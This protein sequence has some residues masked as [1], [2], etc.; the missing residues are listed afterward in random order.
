MFL[1]TTSTPSCAQS[2]CVSSCWS[3]YNHWKGCLRWRCKF[4]SIR[5]T[6]GG[7][8]LLPSGVKLLD[9]D[10][11]PWLNHVSTLL[12][13]DS[14]FWSWVPSRQPIYINST[15]SEWHM[16]SFTWFE[17]TAG[18]YRYVLQVLLNSYIYR[19]L[20]SRPMLEPIYCRKCFLARRRV[21]F[22]NSNLSQPSMC[23]FTFIV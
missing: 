1:T 4:E 15:M 16:V 5:Y 20:G 19:F 6:E 3:V 10:G 23:A 21:Q 14:D 2:P 17:L 8:R 12:G 13:I 11:C 7:A 18:I 22:D 9:I